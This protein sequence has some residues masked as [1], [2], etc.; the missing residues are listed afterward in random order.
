MVQGVALNVSN[1]EG[2]EQYFFLGLAVQQLVMRCCRM[3]DVGRL[4]SFE[5]GMVFQRSSTLD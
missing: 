2:S 4:E 1:Y 5:L 3:I